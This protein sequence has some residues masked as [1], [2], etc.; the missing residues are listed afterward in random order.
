MV[1]SYDD[2][3]DHERERERVG[4]EADSDAPS[5]GDPDPGSAYGGQAGRGSSGPDDQK[6]DQ[7]V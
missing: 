1:S 7:E 6:N 3:Q 4:K 2:D 5:P